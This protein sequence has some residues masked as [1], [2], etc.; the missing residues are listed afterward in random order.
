MASKA[1]QALEAAGR[2]A[3]SARNRLKEAKERAGAVVSDM[4]EDAVRVAATGLV[5]YLDGRLGKDYTIFGMSPALVLGLPAWLAGVGLTLFGHESIGKWVGA[6]GVG[7]FAGHVF[8]MAYVKGWEHGNPDKA[9][10]KQTPTIQGDAGGP[11][12]QLGVEIDFNPHAR[13]HVSTYGG[14]T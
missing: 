4:I 9:K 11:V 5:A 2:A 10:A 7:M 6:V 1:E 14:A 3:A 12:R 13:S 8:K